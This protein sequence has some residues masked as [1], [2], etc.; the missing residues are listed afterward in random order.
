LLRQFWDYPSVSF[1]EDG[2]DDDRTGDRSGSWIPVG[3]RMM[4]M[5][6]SSSETNRNQRA[7]WG[8]PL[9]L[10]CILVH[11]NT[12]HQQFMVE[13]F[14]PTG[15]VLSRTLCGGR[16]NNVQQQQ[17]H[18]SISD[19][20]DDWKEQD[21]TII[22]IGPKSQLIREELMKIQTQLRAHIANHDNVTTIEQLLVSAIGQHIPTLPHPSS[23]WSSLQLEILSPPP[24]TAT[25]TGRNS[26]IH[27]RRT[28]TSHS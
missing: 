12:I 22:C 17:Q 11:W 10:R 15:S 3:Y 25:T 27:E 13:Q 14:D 18:N 16:R 6:Q 21:D 24:I 20:M 2:D 26:I 19:Q 1:E 5:E 7:A 9:G 4:M 23:S 28:I 8:R